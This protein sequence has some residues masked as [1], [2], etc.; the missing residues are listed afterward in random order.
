MRLIQLLICS[1]IIGCHGQTKQDNV[2]KADSI[3]F[4]LLI[5]SGKKIVHQRGRM[6]T[7]KGWETYLDTVTFTKGQLYRQDSIQN[8]LFQFRLS[9]LEWKTISCIVA[10]DEKD[11]GD[12]SMIGLIEKSGDLRI[13][14]KGKKVYLTPTMPVK[15]KEG[16]WMGTFKNDSMEIQISGMLENK[17][18]LRHL[19][20]NGNLILKTSNQIIRETVYLVYENE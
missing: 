15:I 10:L 5:D 1:I 12:K 18:I 20:G 8:P 7:D 19:T 11:Y 14:Y 2:V 16:E 3:K 4:P 9:Y 13:N 17:R 6:T